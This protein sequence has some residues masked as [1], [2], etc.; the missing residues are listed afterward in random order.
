MPGHLKPNRSSSKANLKAT[1]QL[2]PEPE[3]D[4]RTVYCLPASLKRRRFSRVQCSGVVK[5]LRF[6]PFYISRA[7]RY[8][9][10]QDED[11]FDEDMGDDDTEVDDVGSGRRL[12][13]LTTPLCRMSPSLPQLAHSLASGNSA[14]DDEDDEFGGGEDEDD[15]FGG[16]HDDEEGDDEEGDDEEDDDGEV[17]GKEIF[18]LPTEEVRPSREFSLKSSTVPIGSRGVRSWRTRRRTLASLRMSTLASK[19]CCMCWQRS[20]SGGTRVVRS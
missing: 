18:K 14:G 16:D 7:T 19:K 11:E 8:C 15:E 9:Y 17:G 13:A 10:S 5:S 20:K 6:D 3:E 1:K 2:A 4:V 12:I